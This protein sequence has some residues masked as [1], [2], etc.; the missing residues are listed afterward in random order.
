ML[1]ERERGPFL[2]GA[3]AIPLAAAVSL[4]LPH[5][6][7][8]AV[9]DLLQAAE[10]G[11][12]LATTSIRSYVLAFIGIA[13]IEGGLRWVGRHQLIRASRRVEERLKNRL[14]ER[15]QL[16]PLEWFDGA[17]RGDVISRLTQDVELLRFVIGP[18][19]LYGS[20]ALVVVPGGVIWMAFLSPTIALG[21]LGVLAVLGLGTAFVL[22]RL[23]RHSRAV[24]ETI[25]RLSERAQED[26]AGAR[27]WLSFGQRSARVAAM[28][29]LA[30]E[31]VGHNERLVR[32]RALMDLMIHA[33]RNG[34][35]LVVLVLG[36]WTAASSGAA[37]TVGDLLQF[38]ALMG[39]MTWPLLAIGFL[40]ATAQRAL[41]A[42]ERVGEI[43]AA[44]PAPG[45]GPWLLE[46]RP[47]APEPTAPPSVSVRDLTFTFDGR[48]RP[49]LVDVSVEVPAGSF[50]AFVG[51]IGSGKSALLALV[52][53]LREPPAG[54]VFVDGVD[55]V[56]HDLRGLRDRFALA[57]QDAFLFSDTIRANVLFG[58]G[59]DAGERLDEAVADAALEGELAGF[60]RGIDTVVGE[61][62][63]TLSGGQ[64]QRVQFARAFAAR[65]VGLLLDDP[66]SAVDVTTEARIL[67]A[68]ERRHLQQQ[69]TVLAA[70]HRLSLVRRADRIHWMEAGRILEQGTHAE[71]MRIPDGRYAATWRRQNETVRLGGELP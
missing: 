3:L 70:T 69:A 48:S 28:R 6:L 52:Q 31:Y 34:V 56:E 51:P 53:R 57:A 13:A 55:V 47:R 12:P 64:R 42:G 11:A 50:A 17:R 23:H 33:T 20:Q 44:E 54:T 4:L 26:F 59:A 30:D 15:I 35:L 61:R 45:T 63:T 40:A 36:A 39:L 27:V 67:R 29:G 66:L 49:A 37:A 1:L 60:K 19:V 16:L 38:V 41:A 46:P 22:P 14:V 9:D 2:R 25:G 10:S 58:G 18:T 8:R 32:M 43:L 5:L 24:Q 7:G 62:G 68:F 71:L 21:V 65:R